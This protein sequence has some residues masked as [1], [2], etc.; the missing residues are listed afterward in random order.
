MIVPLEVSAGSVFTAGGPAGV[1][2]ETIAPNT[3]PPELAAAA[4]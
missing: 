3:A 4:Q 1:L 2:N